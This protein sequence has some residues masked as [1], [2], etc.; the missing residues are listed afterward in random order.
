MDACGQKGVQ[1]FS[2][3]ADIMHGWPLKLNSLNLGVSHDERKG[4]TAATFRG[5][6]QCAEHSLECG[7][8]SFCRSK[9][10]KDWLT[11]ILTL[12]DASTP[13]KRGSV[14]VIMPIAGPFTRA[15]KGFGKSMNAETNLLNEQ[16]SKI[17][18]CKIK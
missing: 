6:P 13:S 14:V 9:L 1:K 17:L 11:E 15:I 7:L 12:S 4:E 3:C 5:H 16:T 8:K 10:K 2:F 18:S